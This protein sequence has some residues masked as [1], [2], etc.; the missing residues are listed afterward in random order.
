MLQQL[1]HS[2]TNAFL[3]VAM[4]QLHCV[5]F[6]L[7]PR[8]RKGSESIRCTRLAGALFRKH[9]LI[10]GTP[11]VHST[12]DVILEDT[13]SMLHVGFI[14]VMWCASLQALSADCRHNSTVK[15]PTHVSSIKK[16]N[17]ID[18]SCMQRE[19]REE[20]FKRQHTLVSFKSVIS[21]I[22]SYPSK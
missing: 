16:R 12:P 7:S 19:M 15:F 8:I 17:R 10:S 1:S 14:F 13:R 4:N 11:P 21:L 9:P 5:G 22:T 18:V 2:S 6:Y 20:D 3:S